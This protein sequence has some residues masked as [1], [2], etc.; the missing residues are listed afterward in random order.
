M[1]SADTM[2][3][4]LYRRDIWWWCLRGLL[5]LLIVWGVLPAEVW[6]QAQESGAVVLQGDGKIVAMA[7]GGF[8]VA[9]YHPDGS[10][11][12][13][14]G[15]GGKVVTR[16][17]TVEEEAAGLYAGAGWVALQGD[18]KIVAAGKV[19]KSFAVVRYHPDGSL[20]PSFG[21][22]GKVITRLGTDPEIE[23]ELKDMA[24]QA[25]G[26]IV[27]VGRS[28][29]QRSNDIAVVRYHADGSLDTS[30][31]SG[32]KVLTNFPEPVPT[33]AGLPGLY[34]GV[35]SKDTTHS[36]D[37]A[38]SPGPTYI[39]YGYDEAWALVIQ[40][41]GK[42]V[43]G[44]SSLV[45]YTPEGSLDPSFGTGGRVCTGVR[46]LALQPDGKIVA[47]VADTGS[48][49]LARYNSDGSLDPHFG[50][51]GTVSTQLGRVDAASDVALQADGKLVVVGRSFTGRSIDFAMVRYHAD[52]SLDTSFGSGGQVTSDFCAHTV[53]ERHAQDI[54]LGTIQ[55][56]G[57]RVRLQTDG[58]I[59]V[60][61]KPSDVPC[62]FVVW[63]YTG[64]G[65]LDP[66]FGENGRVITALTK[67]EGTLSACTLQRD[68]KLVVAGT[69][70][71]GFA[72][73]RYYPDGSLDP[74]FGQG[75][76]VTTRLGEGY[77]VQ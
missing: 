52:G 30:F 27:V 10:L 37:S 18:G 57:W 40:A 24:V 43:V 31:G 60:A 45:R 61:G 70:G 44:G 26:K 16:F 4:G 73:A 67:Q 14:F 50:S 54:G 48:F 77:T 12:P 55:G 41:D 15:T 28:W 19:D 35:R 62:P 6:P 25:D 66:S 38:P 21:R 65:R 13:S 7:P 72:V 76:K 2:N 29:Q 23:D 59:V 58:K 32:G 9:R 1:V 63:R 17:S 56:G 68:G 49:T 71:A 3:S 39:Q 42:L 46:A 5:L 75:G 34:F 64:D 36:S 22:G 47:V 33:N 74:S 51:G 53:E 69:S 11:D 20:D 8:A